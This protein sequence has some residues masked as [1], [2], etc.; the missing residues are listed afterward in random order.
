MRPFLIPKTDQQAFDFAWRTLNQMKERTVVHRNGGWGC[1]YQTPDL[2]RCVIG[3]MLYGDLSDLRSGI[4]SLAVSKSVLI[5]SVNLDLLIALQMTHDDVAN[6]DRNGFV[7]QDQMRAIA[8]QFV[9]E[10]PE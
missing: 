4:E 2:R 6:W 5:G 10:V 7:G 3:A 9:L 1:V 8:R